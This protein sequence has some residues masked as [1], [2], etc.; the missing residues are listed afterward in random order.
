LLD[1]AGWYRDVLATQLHALRS[2]EVEPIHPD[3]SDT[4]ARAA[5]AWTPE[6]T[7]RRIDAILD[8]RQTMLE[9]PSLTPLLAMEEL[10]LRLRAG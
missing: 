9:L 8:C 7:L 5:R 2:G 3:Q 1:L 6:Q 10:A 4:V